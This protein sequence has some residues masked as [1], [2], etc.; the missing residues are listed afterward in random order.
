MIDLIFHLQLLVG[1]AYMAV[2]GFDLQGEQ[3]MN[4]LNYIFSYF[5]QVLAPFITVRSFLFVVLLTLRGN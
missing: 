2:S 5:D 1:V 3:G 4:G